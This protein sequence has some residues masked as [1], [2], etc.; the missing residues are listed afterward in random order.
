MISGD[1][2]VTKNFDAF[3]LIYS[4]LSKLLFPK[5]LH[6]DVRNSDLEL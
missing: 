4:R 6:A 1:V 5:V 2:L 3:V